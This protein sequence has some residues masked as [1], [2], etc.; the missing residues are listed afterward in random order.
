MQTARAEQQAEHIA[1]LCTVYGI[2]MRA[3]SS[4]GRACRR[5]RTIWI[6]PVRSDVTYIVALHELGHIL[7]KQ[8]HGRVTDEAAA[9]QWAMDNAY[10]DVSDHAWRTAAKAL[11]GYVRWAQVRI[12][13]AERTRGHLRGVPRLPDPASPAWKTLAQIERLAGGIVPDAPWERSLREHGLFDI[14]AG[15]ATTGML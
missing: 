13:R 6:R 7:A 12:A 5:S 11:R 9:W 1:R 8:H 3:H 2:D 4:G 10:G 15:H 14:D